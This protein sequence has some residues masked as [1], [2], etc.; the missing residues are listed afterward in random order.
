[1]SNRQLLLGVTLLSLSSTAC[2]FSWEHRVDAN[3]GYIDRSEKELGLKNDGQLRNSYLQINAQGQYK[4]STDQYFFA[5]ARG[6]Y[7]TDSINLEPELGGQ[8]SKYYLEL[9]QLYFKAD[10]LIYPGVSAILGRKR[11]RDDTGLWWDRDFT[12]ASL[13]IERS[14]FSGF[15]AIGENFNQFRTDNSDY[16]QRDQDL[17]RLLATASWHWRYQQFIDV[18]FSYLNDHSSINQM[19]TGAAIDDPSDPKVAWLGV[20]SHGAGQLNDDTVINY[21]AQYIHQQGDI[22]YLNADGVDNKKVKGWLVQGDIS[23]QMNYLFQPEV[24]FQFAQTSNNCDH[25]TEGRFFQSGLHSNRAKL[26]ANM[27]AINRY[28][29]AYRPELS[30]IQVLGAYLK[31]QFA[32]EVKLNLLL[33]HFTRV[34]TD[35]DI[36][37]SE[38]DVPLVAGRDEL[39]VAADLVV[40]YTP[41]LT[42]TLLNSSTIK[43][44]L[45]SF[46]PGA[47]YGNSV[48]DQRHRA[49]L[50]WRLNF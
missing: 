33:N 20:R 30:N 18:N 40:E 29:D 5:K 46:W 34:N 39:G 31:M 22:S 26:V 48:N 19:I 8:A 44:R 10:N 50:E 1:M 38:I 47:A 37:R 32:A 25:N 27:A 4:L 9:Q 23:A 11:L 45:S 2:A 6:F 49:L 13:Q 12:L 15:I 35:L 42:S 16:K 17:F 28:N 41:Q 24:G 3:V 14:L 21:S 7:S 36:G 43:L